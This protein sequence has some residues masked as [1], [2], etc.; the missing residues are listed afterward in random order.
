MLVKKSTL[1]S[2][3]LLVVALAA[4]L[5]PAFAAEGRIPVFAAGTVIGASGRYIVTNNLV[6]PC[7]S[8][9]ITI[10][11]PATNVD[12]DL[13]GFLLSVP[14]GCM[15]PVIGIATGP[16]GP[17]HVA[18]HDGFLSGGGGS[19]V[20]PA[21][22]LRVIVIED[23]KAHDATGPAIH[24][25]D[26]TSVVIRR[27]EITGATAEGILLDGPTVKS[28]SIENSLV[29]ASVNGIVVTNSSSFALVHNQVESTAFPGPPPA[30]MGNGIT[31]NSPLTCLVS[32]NTVSD[33][34]GEGIRLNNGKGC[35][36]WDNVVRASG[37]N[38]IHLDR[39]TVDTLVLNNNSSG[40]GFGFAGAIGDGLLNEAVQSMIDH[41]QLNSN[42]RI[43]LDFQ[44][45]PGT[46]C[47]NTFGRNTARGNL[48]A[49]APPFACGAGPALFPPNSCNGTA[50]CAVPQSTF[51]DNL[52]P[53]P[54]VF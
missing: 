47:G 26:P 3:A 10:A 44:A 32:E 40:N 4:T 41:N 51:G 38:G 24:L 50:G 12:L 37:S 16:G 1:L 52:I 35:K 48:G 19:I 42:S 28:G 34:S 5:V 45:A 17:D 8:S 25:T 30:G 54:P 7:A 21:G 15:S 39:V 46:G 22:P 49:A 27:V 29:R 2:G 6:A 33:S 14:V 31:L 43:G 13:N 53:G 36:L 20:Q 18:I 23:V 11:A 9:A